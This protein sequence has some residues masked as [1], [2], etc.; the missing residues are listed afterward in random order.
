MY[1][2]FA[3]KKAEKEKQ[4]FAEIYF[5]EK[6]FIPPFRTLLAWRRTARGACPKAPAARVRA[7]DDGRG[8][9]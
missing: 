7:Y 6:H 5:D 2:Y 4:L 9:L 8:L 1:E 3:S